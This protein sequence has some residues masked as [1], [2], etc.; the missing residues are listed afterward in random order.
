VDRRRLHANLPGDPFA[1][2][3]AGLIRTPWN[4]IS[5]MPIP[6]VVAV[7]VSVIFVNARVSWSELSG[8][9]DPFAMAM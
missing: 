1:P 7:T 3:I 6:G 4:R 2:A 9:D 8:P 5:S